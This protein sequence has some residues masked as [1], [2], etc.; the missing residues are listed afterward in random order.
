M[1]IQDSDLF[2]VNRGGNS[3]KTVAS[4]LTSKIQNTDILLINSGGNSYKINGQD[5]LNRNFGQRD[6]FLVNRNNTSYVVYGQDVDRYLAGPPP[7]ITNLTFAFDSKDSDWSYFKGI[8]T[9]EENVLASD[10]K[11]VSFFS[12]WDP[13]NPVQG[14]PT[15]HAPRELKQKGGSNPQT[16]VHTL[17]YSNTPPPSSNPW[18]CRIDTSNVQKLVSQESS[19]SISF[20]IIFGKQYRDFED[21]G[22]DTP[23]SEVMG[24]GG[25]IEDISVG[26]AW[27]NN[28]SI[29]YSNDLGT[30]TGVY[31]IGC[32]VQ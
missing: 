2:L 32:W 16:A 28:S 24:D 9:F 18:L 11:D 21:F 10:V 1:A 6:T 20:S 4:D 5:F 12:Y 13:T 15:Y 26:V 7:T 19:N 23:T 27:L 22:T 30:F 8:V 29:S 14:Q 17:Y 25:T 3:Y 31:P